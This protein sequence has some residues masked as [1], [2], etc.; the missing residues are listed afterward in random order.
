MGTAEQGMEARRRRDRRSRRAG[1]G[2]QRRRNPRSPVGSNFNDGVWAAY[3][4][5]FHLFTGLRVYFHK[6]QGIFC[7]NADDG[8]PEALAGLLVGKD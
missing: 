1:G 8:R 2:A 3:E 6:S 4:T 7:K 5:F